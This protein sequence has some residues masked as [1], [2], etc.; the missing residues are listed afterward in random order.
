M[1]AELQ[2]PKTTEG[3]CPREMWSDSV[4]GIERLVH[5]N[6]AVKYRIL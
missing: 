2:S 5:R 3:S 1:V 4:A 6:Q